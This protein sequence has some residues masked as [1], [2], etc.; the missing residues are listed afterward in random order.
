MVSIQVLCTVGFFNFFMFVSEFQTLNDQLAGCLV[1]SYERNYEQYKNIRLKLIHYH[2]HLLFNP[3]PIVPYD[4]KIIL[5]GKEMK[6]NEEYKAGVSRVCSLLNIDGAHGSALFEYAKSNEQAFGDNSKTQTATY[7]YFMEQEAL[8]N[9]LELIVE[10]A[11]QNKSYEP[12]LAFTET[13]SSLFSSD[14]IVNN[15][16]NLLQSHHQTYESLT[17]LPNDSTT[18]ERDR[19]RGLGIT[20]DEMN[21]KQD[22]IAREIS[23]IGLV[24]NKIA[25]QIGFSDAETISA[26]RKL[27]SLQWNGSSMDFSLLTSCLHNFNNATMRDVKPLGHRLHF[28]S[29]EEI[30]NEIIR[31]QWHNEQ[32]HSAI[33]LAWT[34]SLELVL[35]KTEGEI[36]HF[37]SQEILGLKKSWFEKFGRFAKN[38]Q[39][40]KACV[41][42]TRLTEP[43]NHLVSLSYCQITVDTYRYRIEIFEKYL[44]NFI[45]LYKKIFRS[46]LSKDQDEAS[47]A[48][49]QARKD[50]LANRIDANNELKE[51]V[52]ESILQ[53][54]YETYSNR[55]DA[56]LRWWTEPDLVH[57]IRLA[58]DVWSSRF[59]TVFIHTIAGISCG[60]VSA[61]QA[62]VALNT[63]NS[64]ILNKVTWNAFFRTLSS[65]VERSTQNQTMGV[66]LD[67]IEKKLIL[68]FLNLVGIVVKYSFNA[69]H[70]LN[71]SQH[72]RAVDTLFQLLVSRVENDLKASLLNAIAGFCS[73]SFEDVEITNQVWL[74]IE[75]SQIVR[76]GPNLYQDPSLYTSQTGQKIYE[77]HHGSLASDIA[78]TEV[79]QQS[80]PE[81][82]AF[83]N[84]IKNLLVSSKATNTTYTLEA[85]GASIRVGGVRPFIRFIIQ[86]IF[87]KLD[88]MPFAN[89]EEKWNIQLVCLEIFLVCLESF[90]ITDAISYLAEQS[91]FG[92]NQPQNPAYVNSNVN[93]LRSLGLHPGF[94]VLCLILS[95]SKFTSKLFSICSIDLLTADKY[96]SVTSSV[97]IALK[98]IFTIFQIH[99]P[100]LE[101][102]AP[103]L[104]E[105]R[106]A[107][108]LELPNS[109]DGIDRLLASH[110]DT[111]VRIAA[112]VSC[113]NDIVALLSLHVLYLLSQSATF[114]LADSANTNRLV[115]ILKGSEYRNQIFKGFMDR[116][117]PNC[118]DDE[119]ISPIEDDQTDP[120]Q[121]STFFDVNQFRH[122]TSHC[123]R[124]VILDLLIFN[125]NAKSYP[126]ISHFLLGLEVQKKTV[127]TEVNV[128][129]GSSLN[130]VICLLL[131]TD[132]EVSEPFCITHPILAEKCYHLLYILSSDTKTSNATLKELRNKHNFFGKQLVSFVPVVD[133]DM[134]QEDRSTI[135]IRLHQAAWLLKILALELHVTALQGQRSQNLKI[136]QHLFD[137]K[138][139]TQPYEQPFSKI[140]E[141]LR[142]LNFSGSRLDVIDLSNT[143]FGEINLADFMKLDER[144]IEIFDVETLANTLTSRLNFHDQ[145][146]SL[147]QFG[148]RAANMETL[149][150]IV[151]QVNHKNDL[152]QLYCAR[153]HCSQAWCSLVRVSIKE[154]FDMFAADRRTQHL[155]EILSC[156]L[157]HLASESTSLSISTSMSQA[158]LALMARLQQE[159]Q[160][161]SMVEASHTGHFDFAHQTI[162][163][164]LLECV[165][166]PGSTSCLRGNYYSALNY[167]LNYIKPESFKTRKH[168]RGDTLNETSTAIANLP[169]RFWETLCRDAADSE[170]VWQTVALGTLSNLY[171]TASWGPAFAIAS[172]SILTF[173][174]RRNFLGHF[175]R[176]IKHSDDQNLLA[177]I[178]STPTPST[179]EVVRYVFEAKM[180][181]LIR[182]SS[183]RVGAERL[184]D[185]NIFE[186]LTDCQFLNQQPPN[187]EKS[188]Q[189]ILSLEAYEKF[190]CIVTPVFELVLAIISH[191]VGDR[192]TILSKVLEFVM[193]HQGAIVAILKSNVENVNLSSL[194]QLKLLTGIF[195]W[196][197][198][199][200]KLSQSPIGAAANQNSY[201]SCISEILK[202]FSTTNWVTLLEPLNDIETA[203]EH[204]MIPFL[205]GGGKRTMFMEEAYRLTE[206]ITRN[207]LLFFHSTVNLDLFQKQSDLQMNLSVLSSLVIENGEKLV[208]LNSEQQNLEIKKGDIE[209]VSL[210][211]INDV[212]RE[213]NSHLFH[214][215]SLPQRQQL[216]QKKI[217]EASSYLIEKIKIIFNIV[218]LGTILIANQKQNNKSEILPDVNHAIQKIFNIDMK[219]H[220]DVHLLQLIW[221]KR[222]DIPLK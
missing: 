166:V 115:G 60:T 206:E 1:K 184:L 13:V 186:I 217:T 221:K 97:F 164:P 121:I 90:D 44:T 61:T 172:N 122:S 177:I 133:T 195:A 4:G 70:A 153:F 136:L 24:L 193:V 8:L 27:Q 79:A 202:L 143:I 105:T 31:K 156:L 189:N 176:T 161:R 157:E 100:F 82:L 74:A 93:R 47:A 212:V 73:A 104:V 183:T 19:L 38:Y 37:I 108:V 147:V 107:R 9:C 131:D 203:K 55:P 179:N 204:A 218:E 205:I 99:K 101:T 170:L 199:H 116:L 64:G 17:P 111:V 128:A 150:E 173:M 211:E 54:I 149:Q 76:T 152:Q 68:A 59:L 57:F 190:H 16:L 215:L 88:D 78:D 158:V 188:V 86:T 134:E 220:F 168:E 110:K 103:G 18:Q 201:T 174:T 41:M 94:E 84:L 15:L 89:V 144:N 142:A 135:V 145:V 213:F 165:Q 209:S 200:P 65:Y 28:S 210:D 7:A 208:Q 129:S 118:C 85:V 25:K 30:N 22:R 141:I 185:N 192:L 91:Q 171:Q 214:E 56:A 117:D 112:N 181:L 162:L 140:I 95:G 23:K 109:M 127:D 194:Y 83:L 92:F 63:E 72:Y 167:Y 196:I 10:Y 175:I 33:W 32:L 69:R 36:R 71:E 52:W 48:D 119:L 155:Y 34:C 39:F 46:I 222:N 113:E 123:I 49:E 3:K 96:S 198:V 51:T 125:S 5:N 42:T 124:L 163:K 151:N 87:L 180:T 169:D 106:E 58:A 146:G 219:P 160:T 40:L 50:L 45:S 98:I 120:T 197:G 67:P 138:D 66:V 130:N 6:A 2:S 43:V 80:Y 14:C 178:L 77:S 35:P 216:Y 159:S 102:I 114:L 53:W 20:D 132:K 75:K 29:C 139:T 148:G 191:F 187:V 21:V 137:A 207:S 126:N 11:D 26:I 154:Y 12:F 62:H 81:T 182:L